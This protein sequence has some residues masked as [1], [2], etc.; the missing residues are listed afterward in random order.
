MNRMAKDV[1]KEIV[2]IIEEHGKI[3]TREA[4]DYFKKLKV[5]KRFQEDVY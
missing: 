4:A 1:K 5:D 3:S 2:G